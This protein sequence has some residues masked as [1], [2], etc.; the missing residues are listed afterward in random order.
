MDDMMQTIIRRLHAA[1]PDCEIYAEQLPQGFRTPCLAVVPVRS[2]L[3][4]LGPDRFLLR[5]AFDVRFFPDGVRPRRA[6]REHVPALCDALELLPG[7]RAQD[8]SWEIT[9]NVL[10]FFV[11]YNPILRRIPEAVRQMERLCTDVT[12]KGGNTE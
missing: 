4:R 6:C 8:V 5:S 9:D 1:F 7:L 12:P 11:T 10:H 2:Q 3:E